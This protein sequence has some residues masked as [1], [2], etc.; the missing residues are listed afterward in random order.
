MIM[1][2]VT[3]ALTMLMTTTMVTIMMMTAA[4]MPTMVWWKWMMVAERKRPNK[5]RQFCSL[6]NTVCNDRTVVT[7]TGVMTSRPSDDVKTEIKAAARARMD[8]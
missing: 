2:M 1:M 3:A 7:M 6:Y 8:R 4:T 5:G